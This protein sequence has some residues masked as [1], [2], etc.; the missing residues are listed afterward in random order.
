VLRLSWSTFTERWPLFIG[1]ALTICLGVALV[2]SSLLVLISAAT[3]DVPAGLSASDTIRFTEGAS[4][5]VTVSALTLG[6]SA[7]LAVF[8]VGS[9][10]AFTVA[11]R[12]RELAL[13]RLAGGGRGQLHRLLLGEAVLLGLAGTA[14]G[15]PTGLA[16]MS[17]QA[18]L[19]SALGF[20]P[21]GFTAEWRTWILGVSVGVGLGVALAGVLVAARRAAQVRPLEALR[22]T[23]EA[24]R[25][26]TAGRWV[27]GI[28]FT[29]GAIA[30]IVLAPIGGAAGGMA[31]AVNVALCGSVALSALSPLLVPVVARLLPAGRAGVLG[32]LAR[33]NMRDGVRRS[34]ATAAPLIVLVAL[35]LGQSGALTSFAA[36]GEAQQ[37]RSTV[38]DLVVEA[39]GPV[40]AQVAA[41]P[42][43][44]AASTEIEV[45][46]AVTHGSGEDADTETGLALVVDP[47]AYAIAHPSARA[48]EGLV[49]RRVAGG[50]GG[51]GGAVGDTVG[52]R[53]GETDLGLLPV[54]AAV[55]AGIG[56]GATLLLPLGLAAVVDVAAGPSRTFVA[57]ETG[58]DPGAVRAALASIGTV[59][60]VEEWIA[61]DAAARDATSTGVF[62]VVMGLGGMYALIGVVNS[63]VIGAAARRPEFA[64]AR[65]T[66]LTRGQVVRMA[67][68]ESWGVTAI[69]LVLGAVAA[70]GTL[71]AVLGAT[72]A[73]TG[74]ATLALAWP[75]VLSVV[76]GAFVVTGVTGV[77]T[78]WSATRGNPVTLLVARE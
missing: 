27:I 8:I 62:L 19:L 63:V 32:E 28:L 42:G 54:V 3:L 70:A 24:A 15:V 58:A 69:G 77:L 41:V 61:R 46:V 67:L 44:A 34:A 18:W 9:T 71:G 38:A 11:Q 55:P 35:V 49:G 53:A 78:S 37:R 21:A 40:G 2:Q 65:A 47:A 12:R 45:P 6:F 22:D 13:L 75:L 60:G 56:G 5:A 39:T 25:V 31:M 33:A 57:L 72:A 29:A 10:F 14:A 23:G 76:A 26:M 30:L 66:G 1:A 51:D 16:T 50:P 43:V 4:V 17:F 52:V 68:V 73:V 64:A 48:L 59:H 36:A 74:H 7:F 20:V